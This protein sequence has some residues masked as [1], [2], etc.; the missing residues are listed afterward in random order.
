MNN[1]YN[2][3][4]LLGFDLFEKFNIIEERPNTFKQI[5]LRNPY[6]F[7]DEGIINNFGFSDN[8]LL[9]D[10]IIGTLKTEKIN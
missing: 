10:I 6:Y 2:V 7:T 9:P 5:K 4:K 8:N 1:M 3:C